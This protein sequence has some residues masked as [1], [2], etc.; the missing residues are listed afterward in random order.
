MHQCK[1][2]K[3]HSDKLSLQ[4]ISCFLSSDHLISSLQEI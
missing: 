3:Y 2:T 1:T 4:V